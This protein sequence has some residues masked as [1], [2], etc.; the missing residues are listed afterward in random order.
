MVAA[1]LGKTVFNRL[2]KSGVRLPGGRYEVDASEEERPDALCL[3]CGEWGHVMAKCANCGGPHGTRAD[4]C[5]A[6]RIAQHAARGWRSPPPPKKER[7]AA[8]EVAA[9]A[10]EEEGELEVEADAEPGVEGMEE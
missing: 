10:V 1:V 4:A 8:P 2:C 6:K 9:L 5:T 7:K 3:R